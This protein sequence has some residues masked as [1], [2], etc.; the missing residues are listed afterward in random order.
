[1]EFT[2]L[3]VGRGGQSVTHRRQN[4]I[5]TNIFLEYSK[6]QSAKKKKNLKNVAIVYITTEV[7]NVTTDYDPKIV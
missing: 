5:C 7:A 1:M 4:F 2:E 3:Q 6:H